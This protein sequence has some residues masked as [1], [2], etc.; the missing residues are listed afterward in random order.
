M[1]AMDRAMLAEIENRFNTLSQDEQLWLLERLVR[2]LR[3]HSARA[4]RTSWE[5]ELAQMA[6]DP[7]IQAEM[8]KIE[9]EFRGTEADGLEPRP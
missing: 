6:A 7:E 1:A 2:R 8:R 5:S 3:R 9:A 4:K